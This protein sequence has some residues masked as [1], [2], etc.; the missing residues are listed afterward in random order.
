MGRGLAEVD[1]NLINPSGP[2]VDFSK[3]YENSVPNPWV[4]ALSLRLYSNHINL[5]NARDPYVK[6][7]D[8]ELLHADRDPRTAMRSQTQQKMQVGR[9]GVR[10]CGGSPHAASCLLA[11]CFWLAAPA[12][13]ACQAA[14]GG[15]RGAFMRTVN[16]HLE[17]KRAELAAAALPKF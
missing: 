14:A 9:G 6:I 2:L 3:C 4:L 13:C 11:A 12:G 5:E 16:Q 10:C 15:Y 7:T 8:P 1:S 17:R